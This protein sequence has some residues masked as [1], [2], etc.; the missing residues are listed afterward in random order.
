MR[1]YYEIR[2]M[3]IVDQILNYASLQKQ[4]FRRRD[5]MQFLATNNVS[6]ASAH[7]LLKRL[8]EQGKLV[9]AGYGLYAHPEKEKTTFIYKPSEEELSMA[10]QIKEKFP[11]A[12]FCVWKPSVLV[13]YMRHIPALGMT[14]IDVERVAMESVFNF[15]QGDG[16]SMSILLNPT[17]QECERYITTDKLLIVRLLVNEAPLIMANDTPVPTLEKILVDAAGDKELVFAQGA[18]LYTIY[19]EAFSR[20]NVNR[21]RLLRYAARRHRKDQILKIINTIES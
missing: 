16:P 5:L 21:S 18:E 11:F 3:T 9:K 10:K 4:P 20:H 14:L 19:E 2:I 15:L 12:D 7:V 8:V 17:E 6:E 13:P 1:P